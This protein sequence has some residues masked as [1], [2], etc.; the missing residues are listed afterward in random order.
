MPEE[1]R[2]SSTCWYFSRKL[3]RIRGAITFSFRIGVGIA[4]QVAT[5]QY[6]LYHSRH[7]TRTFKVVWDS[8]G[9]FGLLNESL[10]HR[11]KTLHERREV[12]EEDNAEHHDGSKRDE[13]A[14]QDDHD[15][16]RHATEQISSRGRERRDA[17]SDLIGRH[18][19]L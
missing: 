19:Q 8:L 13:E 7:K 12:L 11:T 17:F 5:R 9:H 14:K 15:R 3:S 10:D 16:T 4:R 18:L 2:L 1:V 6:P